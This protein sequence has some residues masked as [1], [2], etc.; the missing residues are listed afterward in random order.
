ML[1]MFSLDQLTVMPTLESAMD[2]DLK[3][4]DGQMRIWLSRMTV[5]DGER[6]DSTVYV[7][8]YIDTKWILV[9]CYDAGS[10]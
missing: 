1:M 9:N 6:Y 4:D 7:E 10:V 5:S 3:Y 2:S 8:E